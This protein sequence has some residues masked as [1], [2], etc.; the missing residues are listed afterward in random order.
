VGK[1]DLRNKNYEVPQ[2]KSAGKNSEKTHDLINL[3][4]VLRETVL[5]G[6]KGM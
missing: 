3:D 2:K 6:T 5:P 4:Q 1:D